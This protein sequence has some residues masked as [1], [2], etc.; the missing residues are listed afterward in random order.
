MVNN[1]VF[2][3][4]I[5][6]KAHELLLLL[7]ACDSVVYDACSFVEEHCKVTLRHSVFAV[8]FIAIKILVVEPTVVLCSNF[9]RSGPVIRI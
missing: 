3:G 1:D 2:I 7:I 6:D 4:S 5:N 9:N 8:S